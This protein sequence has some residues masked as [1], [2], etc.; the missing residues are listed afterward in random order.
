MGFA[1]LG[2][3]AQGEDLHFAFDVILGNGSSQSVPEPGDPMVV[4][5]N[6]GPLVSRKKSLERTINM[7]NR[8]LTLAAALVL[9]AAFGKFFALPLLAQTRAAL[10]QNMDER[11]R[12]PYQSTSIN[13][14]CSGTLQ[15]DVFFSTVPT[16][17]RL[18][19]TH[20]DTFVTVNN[21]G[22]LINIFVSTATSSNRAYPEFTAGPQTAGVSTFLSSRAV[23]LYVDAGAA[24]LVHFQATDKVFPLSVT[25]TGYLLGCTIGCA[26]IAQ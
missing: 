11:G 20:V 19:I 12:I 18:V 9:V 5:D 13:S 21:T 16:N 4:G 15:C 3:L 23:Q 25:L 8:L 6:P 10:V 1:G 26:A 22:S 17:K 2:N 14:N 24:A 7:K